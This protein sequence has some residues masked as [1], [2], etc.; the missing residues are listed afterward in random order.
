MSTSN[1][2]I[3]LAA[4]VVDQIEE[5][6]LTAEGANQPVEVEPHRDRLFELFVLAD[7]SGFMVEDSDPDLTCDGIGR[8]LATRWELAKHMGG[9]AKGSL[10]N[11]SQMPAEQ[12]VKMR[13]LWSFMRM[14]MEWTYAWRRWN[15]FHLSAQR[16]GNDSPS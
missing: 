3:K 8:E 10:P 5:L 11:P 6:L 4:D 16:K 9:V 14:W 15:E 2:G 7:A 13:L 12:L 1:P